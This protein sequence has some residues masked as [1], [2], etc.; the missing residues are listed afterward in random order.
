MIT[1]CKD[2]KII[3]NTIPFT[4]PHST[5]KDKEEDILS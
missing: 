3:K 5:Q 4:M 2:S 1:S